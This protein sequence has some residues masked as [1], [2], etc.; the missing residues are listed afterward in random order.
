MDR[1]ERIVKARKTGERAKEN[2]EMRMLD[3]AYLEG[4][5]SIEEAVRLLK[6]FE[7]GQGEKQNKTEGQNKAQSLL[8]G[9]FRL[10]G[11]S[12]QKQHEIK[13]EN[14]RSEQQRESQGL[15]CLLYGLIVAD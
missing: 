14:K 2:A 6:S 4:G 9:E 11:F 8:P 1:L 12:N 5:L 13:E 7:K 3:T 10:N 15:L